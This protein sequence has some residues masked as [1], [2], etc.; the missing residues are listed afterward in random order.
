MAERPR[1]VVIF[2]GGTIS[3]LPDPRT[4]AAIPTLRGRELLARVP[5]L[6]DLA[7]LEA[8]D[9][10]LVPASH[11]SLAQILEIGALISEAAA[12]P[13]VDGVV[14][15]QGTD[16]LEETAFAWDLLHDSAVPVAVVGAMR[17]AGDPDY[18]GPR[19]LTHAVLVAA[20]R[21]LR[22]QGVIVVMGG[23]ILPADDVTKVDSDALDT[24]AALNTGRLGRVVGGTV[25]LERERGPHRALRASPRGEPMPVALVT[26]AVAIDGSLLRAAVA[27]GVRGVVVEATGSGNTDADLLAAA[28][29]TMGAGVPVVLATRCASGAVGTSYGFP[30][31][32]A[33]WARAG[34][35]MA[36]TLSG[37]KAR[38]A[39]MLGLA[40][41]LDE[42]GLRGLIEGTAHDP[43]PG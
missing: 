17:N 20:D 6:A 5:G 18:D 30:G 3:M 34:A 1:V 4:G 42:A 37:P 11:L 13:D 40:A 2:T 22:D 36:G 39:L 29:E 26:A 24:F 31:G 25:Q 33:T 28:Q 9:W 14:V 12:R 35:I 38:I 8:V 10:G 16:V 27:G 43:I 21:R 23:L 19:N 15:V 32:G 41:G 7:E